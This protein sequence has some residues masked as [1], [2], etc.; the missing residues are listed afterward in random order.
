M[1]FHFCHSAHYCVAFRG[2][3]TLSSFEFHLAVYRSGFE[4]HIYNFPWPKRNSSYQ[5]LSLRSRELRVV[6]IWR[7]LQALREIFFVSLFS[8]V[9]GASA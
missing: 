7:R 6:S 2:C 1:K 5:L 3:R 8:F 9:R 4:A